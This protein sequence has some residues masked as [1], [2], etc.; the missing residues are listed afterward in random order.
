MI[1]IK[2]L[3][4]YYYRGTPKEVRAVDGLSFT[5]PDNGMIALFG[6]SGCGK[7]TLLNL[8]GGLDF[9]SE[10]T[11]LVDGVAITPDADKERNSDIGYIFQNYNLSKKMTVEE[12]VASALRLCG[13]TDSKIISERVDEA[14]SCVDMLKFKKRYPTALSGGQQQR[15]AIAR[16]IV[17]QPKI[18]LADEPTGNLDDQNTVM[19]MDLLKTISSSCTVVLV[20]HELELVN[21]YCDRIIELSDGGVT[22]DREN[23]SGGSYTAKNQNEIYLG[24]LEH[25]ECT[26]GTHSVEFYGDA[27]P[28]RIRLISSGGAVYLSVPDGVKVKI[29]DKGSEVVIR[30]GK[31]EPT[32]SVSEQKPITISTLDKSDAKKQGRLYGFLDSFVFA[33]KN[34]FINKKRSRLALIS[35]L[36]LLAFTIVL[37]VGFTGT[38]FNEMTLIDEQYNRNTVYIS[39]NVG[40]DYIKDLSG[41]FD[42]KNVYGIYHPEYISSLPNDVKHYGF[43]SVSF[44]SFIRNNYTH[45]FSVGM[46]ILPITDLGADVKVL[47]G[48][49]SDLDEGEIVITRKIADEMLKK[50]TVD[51]VDSYKKLLGSTSANAKYRVAGIVEGDDSAAYLSEAGYCYKIFSE[52]FNGLGVGV[53]E[54]VEPEW[55][56]PGEGEIYLSKNFFFDGNFAEVGK[57]VKILGSDFRVTKVFDETESQHSFQFGGIISES[58]LFR[59]SKTTNFETD[60][61]FGLNDFGMLNY[62]V[63]YTE[64]AERLAN[65]AKDEK[66]SPSVHVVAPSDIYDSLYAQSKESVVTAITTVAILSVI[67]AVCLYFIMRSMLLLEIKEIGISRAIGAGKG[68]IIFRFFTESLTVF[69]FTELIGYLL[70][71]GFVG[72]ISTLAPDS[73]SLFNLSPMLA[74]I[75]LVALFATSIVCGLLPVLTLLR[76]SPAEILSQ[77]DI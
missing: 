10:G 51:F 65:T 58:E 45:E 27:L 50:S 41:R 68:N 44:D 35:S 14:L 69:A 73:T 25:T 4:K 5:L 16:A 76:K 42:V 75:T 23:E 26:D 46:I 77:Y 30:E 60:G 48:K 8:V 54:K 17:K 22:S 38:V 32:G 64:S 24:D 2:G 72:Y 34:N 18:I 67:I 62:Y 12:N 47:V 55:E 70:G 56:V 29:A 7:T 1:E 36:V 61:E 39:T 49:V 66:G 71:V 63:L 74:I 21:H 11:V 31:K 3:K 20:T 6:K 15:V 33:F 52:S 9:A 19:V 37:I 28:D 43:N 53:C 59:L 57:T 40:E 13:I